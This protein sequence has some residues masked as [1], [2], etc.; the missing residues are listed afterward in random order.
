MTVRLLESLDDAAV[1]LNSGPMFHIGGLRRTIAV[2]HAGGLNVFC[3]R[4]D[5]VELCRL[6]DAEQ[7]THAFLQTPTMAQMVLANS[8]KHFNLKSLRSA[9]GPDGWNDMVTLTEPGVK[10]GYGQTEVAGVV[11]FRHPG[12]PSVGAV[13][14]PLA[15][16]EVHTPEGVPVAPGEI[17]EIVVRGPVVMNGYHNRQELNAFRGRG[18][19]H[20]TNDLGRLE[21]DG[22]ISFIAPLQRIIKSAAENIYPSEVEAA[23]LAHPAVTEAA[24]LGVPDAQWGQRVK[25]IVVVAKDSQQDITADDLLAFCRTRLAGYKC[26]RLFE[27]ADSLPRSGGQ[28][29]RNLLDAAYGGGGYPGTATT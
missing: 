14:G 29:D 12:A 19:W 20:H 17:G 18:G 21:H 5:A 8:G 28:L 6:I 26:P 3:R 15:R 7:C 11:T 25:A 16:V 24:V 9:G 4:V 13:P 27:F 22:S 23:L 2:A 1:Y 10:S